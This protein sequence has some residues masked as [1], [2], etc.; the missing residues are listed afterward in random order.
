[1]QPPDN[2]ASLPAWVWPRAAYIHVPFCAH[3]CGYCDFAIATGKDHLIE[4]YLDALAAAITPKT[5]LLL[6]NTPHNPTGKV[7]SLKELEFIAA[8]CREFDV[9]AITDEIYEHLVYRSEHISIATLEGMRERTVTISG[10]SKTYSVTGWRLAYAIAPPALTTAIRKVHD[11]VT[12]GAPHPLQVAAA[13]ALA[14]PDQYYVCPLY[15]FDAADDPLCVDF[16]GRVRIY[17]KI[18]IKYASS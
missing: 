15:T 3:H 12:V 16:G 9:L 5:R 13:T 8:A 4:L 18:T 2:S 1:V 6:I 17:N 7:Y 10:L 14:F 11:F